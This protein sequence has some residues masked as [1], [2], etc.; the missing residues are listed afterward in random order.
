VEDERAALGE[1][2]PMYRYNGKEWKLYD[3]SRDAAKQASAD[4]VKAHPF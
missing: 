1:A 2:Y 3:G 4:E